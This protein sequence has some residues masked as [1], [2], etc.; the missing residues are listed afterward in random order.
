MTNLNSKVH[1]AVYSVDK[2][3]TFQAITIQLPNKS[4][5]TI[6]NKINSKRIPTDVEEK[7]FPFFQI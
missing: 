1:S 3:L 4:S 2:L 5:T 6:N 7:P